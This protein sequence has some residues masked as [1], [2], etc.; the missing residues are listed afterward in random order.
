MRPT[1]VV[2]LETGMEY[3]PS[4]GHICTV[5]GRVFH[6]IEKPSPVFLRDGSYCCVKH[7]VEA[8]KAHESADPYDVDPKEGAFISDLASCINRHSQE[9]GSD[10]PDFILAEFLTTCLL[11]WNKATK[12]RDKWYGE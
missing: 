5:C 10:T 1:M 6:G 11:A 7:G 4:Y 9:N 8:P 3:H 2:D 12:Q